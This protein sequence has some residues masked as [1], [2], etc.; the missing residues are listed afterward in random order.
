M[1]EPQASAW[2]SQRRSVGTGLWWVNLISVLAPLLETSKTIFVP[3]HSVLSLT[4]LG[5]PLMTGQTTL[6][7]GSSSAYR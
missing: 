5:P 2:E 7:P 1:G 6:L 3:L 4:N